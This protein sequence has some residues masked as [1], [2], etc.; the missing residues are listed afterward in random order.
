[1]DDTPLLH[2]RVSSDY[3]IHEGDS[4][5]LRNATA[6]G[7]V[8]GKISTF[9]ELSH[10]VSIGLGGVDMM[11]IKDVLVVFEDSQDFHLGGKKIA[12]H[13]VIDLLHIDDLN[14]HF[15]LCLTPAL[16]VT[17]LRPRYT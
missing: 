2:G 3:L 10:N 7:Y 4:F 15:F 11:E 5:G 8:L 14:G 6:T 16:P 1:M 9:A 12:V 17:S 13:L